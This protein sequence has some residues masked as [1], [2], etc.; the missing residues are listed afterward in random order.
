MIKGILYKA[1]GLLLSYIFIS[2]DPSSSVS[3]VIVNSTNKT[4]IVTLKE[5]VGYRVHSNGTIGEW[6]SSTDKSVVSLASDEYLEQ[7]QEWI[8]SS[9]QAHQPLWENLVSIRIGEHVC[10]PD[11]WNH[12]DAWK[13]QSKEQSFFDLEHHDYILFLN[14]EMTE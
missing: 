7:V 5:N 3:Y 4:A 14:M 1:L 13:K 9:P 11:K 12:A 2:C 8:H 6:Q 10:S